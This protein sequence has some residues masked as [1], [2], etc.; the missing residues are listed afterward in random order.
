MSSAAGGGLPRAAYNHMPGPSAQ[1]DLARRAGVDLQMMF[2]TP[3]PLRRRAGLSIYRLAVDKA[4]VIRYRVG[5]MSQ[6]F[7][8]SGM[9]PVLAWS[10]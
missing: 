9:R 1:L 7:V 10:G 5:R 8:L 6:L 4:R 2:R 3:N